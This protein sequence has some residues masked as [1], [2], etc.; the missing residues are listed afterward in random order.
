MLPRGVKGLAGIR[1]LAD[2]HP[3][4]TARPTSL[5]AISGAITSLDAIAPA[6][7]TPPGPLSAEDTVLPPEAISQPATLGVT[8]AELQKIGITKL[9]KDEIT[10]SESLLCG[11]G[12]DFFLSCFR[13]F[14]IS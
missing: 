13:P 8:E 10:K 4:E 12:F 1:S 11:L 9:R 14:V 3:A 7:P 2:S 6:A 5:S